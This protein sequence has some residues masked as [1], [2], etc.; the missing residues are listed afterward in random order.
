MLGPRKFCQRDLTLTTFLVDEWRKDPNTTQSRQ[1]IIV[2]PAKRHLMT[3]RW[4]ADDGPALNAGLVA[5]RFA[6]NTGPVLLR[7]TIAL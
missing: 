1:D 6:K 5:S 4:R 7:S 3:F 2:P